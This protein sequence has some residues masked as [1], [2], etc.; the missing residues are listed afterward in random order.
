ML[1]P[2]SCCLELPL[3]KKQSVF[4]LYKGHLFINLIKV[5]IRQ[6]DI[7]MI[8]CTPSSL[9]PFCV[10][11][12]YVHNKKT[13]LQDFH[14]SHFFY[15]ALNETLLLLTAT[16]YWQKECSDVRAWAHVFW[17]LLFVCSSV[18]Y[19]SS[20][21]VEYH[22]SDSFPLKSALANNQTS[23]CGGADAHTCTQTKAQ[24]NGVWVMQIN[25]FDLLHFLHFW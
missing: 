17:T 9:C 1:T 15:F 19:N 2:A 22:G 13:A 23:V 4:I 14:G 20:C 12:L 3:R 6:R 25:S 7:K 10:I 21:S 11:S 8:Y 18:S 24:S 5:A 16:V